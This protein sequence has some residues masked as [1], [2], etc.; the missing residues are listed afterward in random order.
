MISGKRVLCA[1][2]PIPGHAV[3]TAALGLEFQRAGNEVV[4]VTHHGKPADLYRRVGL[5]CIDLRPASRRETLAMMLDL[6]ADFDPDITVCDWRLDLWLA[7]QTF[8]PRCRVSVLRCEQFIGYVRRSPFLPDKFGLGK[9]LPETAEANTVLRFLNQRGLSD[10]RTLYR[11]EAIVVPSL[12]QLDPPPS[13]RDYP[14][15]EIVYTG[16]LFVDCFDPPPP[17]LGIWSAEQRRQG[18][19][20]VLV[21]TGTAWGSQFLESL[22]RSMDRAGF[23]CVMAIADEQARRTV[24]G[25]GHPHLL[26]VDGARLQDLAAASDAVIH[27][28]GHGTLQAVILAGKPSI[29]IPSFE[30]DREDNALRIEELGCG[31]HLSDAVYRRGLDIEQLNAAVDR[32]LGDGRIAA[33]TAAM[34]RT[35]AEFVAERGA[36]HLLRVLERKKLVDPHRR[37]RRIRVRPSYPQARIPGLRLLRHALRTRLGG[38]RKS[39]QERAG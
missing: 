32:V 18:R 36:G 19:A 33:A 10:L 27:H 3:P 29:T 35:M 11:T 28:C 15:S 37:R 9:P 1:A 26:I 8:A 24:Q 16:P 12:P 6:F 39:G 23:S 25:H 21:T 7:Q 5:A 20:V 31:V 2:N 17:S 30:Y 13:S 22:A 4:M 14:D 38:P 34:S